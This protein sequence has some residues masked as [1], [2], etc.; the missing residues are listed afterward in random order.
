MKQSALFLAVTAFLIGCSDK[1]KPNV[2]LIQDFM[3]SPTLKSQEYDKNSPDHRA[4][5]VP[6]EGTHAIGHHRYKFKG[7]PVAAENGNI[8]PYAGKMTE[9]IL[10]QGIKNYET[11]CMVCH[12]VKGLGD[13]PVAPKMN[14][15]PPSLVSDKIKN[16]KD[17]RIYA[18]I[19]E[20]QGLMGSYA[21]HIPTPEGRW[22]VVN[23]IRHLQ[24]EASGK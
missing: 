1:N 21:S 3:E 9:E 24:K 7:D 11:H 22:A 23:Y 4:M 20:G 13:G 14:L 12:G 6:P 16:W 10:M 18:V 17:G 15:K 2:E 19:Y 5:R 8:N